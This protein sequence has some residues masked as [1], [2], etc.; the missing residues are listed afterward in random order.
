MNPYSVKE[1]NDFL[2]RTGSKK[3]TSVVQLPLHVPLVAY[4]PIDEFSAMTH[5]KSD[6]S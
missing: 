5:E 1:S 3:E 2:E 6:I 4:V